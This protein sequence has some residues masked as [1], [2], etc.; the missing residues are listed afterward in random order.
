[1]IQ[2]AVEGE[3]KHHDLAPPREVS[4]GGGYGEIDVRVDVDTED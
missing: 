1:M 4:A 3:E 2:G